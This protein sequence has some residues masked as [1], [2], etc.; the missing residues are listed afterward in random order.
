ME[1][2]MSWL[3]QQVANFGEAFGTDLQRYLQAA[4]VEKSLHNLAGMFGVRRFLVRFARK[5]NLV[6]VQEVESI[7]LQFGG[8]PPTNQNRETIAELERA[9]TRLRNNMIGGPVWEY[10]LIGFVRDCDNQYELFPFFDDD[11]TKISLNELPMPPSGHPLEGIEYKSL[12]DSMQAQIIPIIQRSQSTSHGWDV[13]QVQNGELFLLYGDPEQP[14]N[15]VRKKC[16]VLGTFGSNY[17]WEWQVEEPLFKEEVFCW[18][19]FLCDWD[20]AVELGFVCTARME[21]DWLFFSV[22][23]GTEFTLFVAV[24]E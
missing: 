12:H 18:E 4:G 3:E 10:G 8:G 24:W 16:Q 9:L 13:W 1:G 5:G 6:S 2:A 21:A 23:E 7:A 20:S 17:Y 11:S 15:V 22:V 14:D 19:N